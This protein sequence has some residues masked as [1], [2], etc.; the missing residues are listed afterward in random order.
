MKKINEQKLIE[1]LKH[2]SNALSGISN[3]IE[4]GVKGKSGFYFDTQK[5]LIDFD[6]TIAELILSENEAE[7]GEIELPPLGSKVGE[8][9]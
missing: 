2:L 6:K 7:G 5:H 1:A 8:A 9:K 4:S 3:Q